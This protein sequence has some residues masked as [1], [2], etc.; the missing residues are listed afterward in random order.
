MYTTT[1]KTTQQIIEN[2]YDEDLWYDWFCKDSQ[3]AKRGEKLIEFLRQIVLTQKFDVNRT[4]VFFK[5]NCPINGTLYD[6]FRI[7]DMM[8]GDVIYTIIPSAGH[9]SIKG[10][11]QVF[12]VDNNFQEPLIEG[13]WN[14]VCKFF[15]KVN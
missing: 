3:L 12:G 8:S 11:S 7:C 5:N 13:S 2:G 1:K 6:D 15:L 14:D 10:K 4:Y 9:A